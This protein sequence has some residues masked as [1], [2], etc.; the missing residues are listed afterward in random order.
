MALAV[1]VGRAAKVSWNASGDKPRRL[2][3]RLQEEREVAKIRMNR[4]GEKGCF[5]VCYTV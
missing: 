4:M 2:S 1:R 3:G 5:N